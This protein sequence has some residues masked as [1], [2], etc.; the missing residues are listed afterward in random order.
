MLNAVDNRFVGKWRGSDEGKVTQGEVNFWIMNRKYD[1]TFEMVF[2]THFEDGTFEQILEFGNWYV[3]Y[4]VFHE[5]RESDQQ[6]DSYQFEFI[7][8]HI[9]QFIE[10]NSDNKNPYIFK[11]FRL[12]EN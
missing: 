2:E 4:D 5:Y 8:P 7:S 1:G 12:I 9:I 10:M 11:D 3:I 6:T